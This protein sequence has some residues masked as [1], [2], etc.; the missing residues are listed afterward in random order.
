RAHSTGVSFATLSASHF[1]PCRPK[2]TCARASLP[3]PSSVRITPSPNLLWNTLWPD[4]RPWPE[5]LAWAAANDG[6][7]LGAGA[8]SAR[9]APG[10]QAGGYS[11]AKPPPRPWVRGVIHFGALSGNSSK[12]RLLMW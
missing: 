10:G 3:A 9:P 11:R 6:G 7:T 12:K 5:A 8:A 2:L 4:R 1:V